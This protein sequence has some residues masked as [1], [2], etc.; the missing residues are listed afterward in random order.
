M[1][2]RCPRVGSVTRSVDARTDQFVEEYAALD[3][4]TATFAGISGHD[5][6]LPD[7]SPDG[8]AARE[9]L[10]RAAPPPP[11][12]VRATRGPPP[13]PPRRRRRPRPDR[14]PGGGRPRRVPRA[15]RPRR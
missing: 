7:L 6:E 11:R 2:A 15:D 5:H 1:S 4:I 9:D 12:R 14:R 3:P 8:F 10:A 13:R